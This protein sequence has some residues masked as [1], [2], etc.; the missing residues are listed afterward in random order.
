[1]L[2]CGGWRHKNILRTGGLPILHNKSRLA[3]LMMQ[4]AH[5]ESTS[6]LKRCCGRAVLKPGFGRDV[7]W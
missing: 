3:Y 1:M 2:Q 5:A 6:G 4:E 7:A